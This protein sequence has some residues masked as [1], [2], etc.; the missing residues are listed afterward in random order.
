MTRRSSSSNSTISYQVTAPTY[1]TNGY[2]PPPPLY[3]YP[4][5]EMSEFSPTNPYK[6]GRVQPISHTNGHSPYKSSVP[7]EDEEIDR[8]HWGSKAEFI[9]SCVGFSVSLSISYLPIQFI[10]KFLR[11]IFNSLIWEI[12]LGPI[13]NYVDKICF[14]TN[15]RWQVNF[16][17]NLMFY[18][19][20]THTSS[21]LLVIVVYEWSLWFLPSLLQ[22]GTIW[23]RELFA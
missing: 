8:G 13:I 2:P 21:P 18:R 15:L 19:W 23:K 5:Y 9:L 10:G 14:L 3:Q 20:H 1:T 17:L 6:N 7:V 11:T 12:L 22:L 4:G 16:I